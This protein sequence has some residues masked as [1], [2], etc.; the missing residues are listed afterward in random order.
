MKHEI[1]KPKQLQVAQ[2]AL[3]FFMA[4]F[5]GL[6]TTKITQITTQTANTP[7]IMYITIIKSLYQEEPMSY[8]LAH[9]SS[10]LEVPMISG[11]LWSTWMRK[12]EKRNTELDAGVALGIQSA[13]EIIEGISTIHLAVESPRND[14]S[15]EC[16]MH[17]RC[18]QTSSS[19]KNR[20][21]EQW[22]SAWYYWNQ[23]LCN[24][25]TRQFPC[26]TSCRRCD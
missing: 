7:K 14:H 2:T 15:V 6:T 23:W 9:D 26:N 17:T 5:F 12:A 24:K 18:Q 4:F 19:R 25:L 1:Q 21:S 8:S 10:L 20:N 13:A 16:K 22:R 3:V 11:W